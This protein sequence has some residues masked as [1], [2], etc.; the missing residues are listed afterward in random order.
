MIDAL[1]FDIG[2]VLLRF[3]FTPALARLGAASEVHDP[4]QVLARIDQVKA[5]YE[6]GQID[7]ASF[8]RSCFDVLRYHGTE[9]DFVAV[10]EDI[11][12][13][14][15]PMIALVQQ[16]H[17]R[18]PLY[19]LSNTSDI[20]RESIFRRHPFFQCFTAG[21]YSYEAHLMKPDPAIYE[22]T[23]RQ[24]ALEPARTFFIDDL[25][26]NIEAAR[27]FGFRSHHYH[28]DQHHLLLA[29]LTSLGV[30]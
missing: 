28:H 3:D 13:P 19:L 20:H 7:R 26:P 11:F 29:E 25:L 6:G 12:E 5:A 22:L 21:V 17:G 27:A 30:I 4:V 14:N 8:L 2:N 16:L 23:A 15:E 10:W 24:L 18:I 9:A 1:L